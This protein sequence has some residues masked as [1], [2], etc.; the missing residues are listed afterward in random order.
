KHD[1]ECL[2]K[3]QNKSQYIWL[4]GL[5]YYNNIDVKE[6]HNKAFELFS[7][8]KDDCSIAQVYF[9]KCFYD[10]YGT[11]KNYN[12]AFN[13]Y[14]KSAKNKSIIGQYYLANCYQFGIGTRKNNKKAFKWYL[15]S[16]KKGNSESQNYLG[17]CYVNS[18]GV[19]NDDKKAFKWYFKSAKNEYTEGQYNL[20]IVIDLNPQIGSN[21]SKSYSP[22][23]TIITKGNLK[24]K[25]ENSVFTSLI[26]T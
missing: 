14:Q 23:P 20:V 26:E 16:S 7:N 10:G 17:Y 12:I 13:Y 15:E 4:F 21:V 22:I 8:A 11:E 1:E 24:P 5:L 6:N 9:A 18:I 2:T 19:E 25:L 3:N